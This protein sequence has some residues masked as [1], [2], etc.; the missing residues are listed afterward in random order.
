MLLSAA[1][2]KLAPVLFAMIVIGAVV[3]VFVSANR[4][5]KAL[6]EASR[7]REMDFFAANAAALVG[8]MKENDI[9][10]NETSAYDIGE[11]SSYE[12]GSQEITTVKMP[13]KKDSEEYKKLIKGNEK[14]VVLD[15]KV[16]N[17]GDL[18]WDGFKRFG[19]LT[20]YDRTPQELVLERMQDATLV[21]TNKAVIT[22]EIMQQCPKLKY[23]GVIATGYNVVDVKAAAELNVTVTNVP[24]YGTD[25]VA[26][27]TFALMLEMCNQVG[28]HNKSVLDGEW[29]RHPDFSYWLAPLNDV[30]GKKLGIVG[31]GSIGS[32]VA[33]IALAFGMEVFVYSRTRK[34]TDLGVKWVTFD[35][36][37]AK[38]DIITL[39]CPLT[40]DNEKLI[41]EESI[42]KM[43]NGVRLIN[44]ARGG[45]VDETALVDALNSGKLAGAAL[46]V[47]SAEPMAN[48][49]P[50]LSAKNIIITPHIAWASHEAR[51]RLMGIAIRNMEQ[52][53]LDNPENVVS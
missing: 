31:F 34:N 1:G 51:E 35:E 41:N 49:S 10:G 39:H 5:M 36:L 43:K 18:S 21:I 24:G 8:Q 19:E 3:F 7:K 50:L 23:I 2:A 40:A 32:K 27:F 46:D 47:I 28:M 9:C 29:C 53:L 22:R 15:G 20:V 11:Q 52:F 4:K 25:A 48:D 17:P 45:L 44:T 13:I 38:A 14:I 30:C 26:Q 16:L 12:I 33:E 6:K 37:L 42:S